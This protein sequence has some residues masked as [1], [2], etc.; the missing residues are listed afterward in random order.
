MASREHTVMFLDK[1]WRE[2]TREGSLR[3]ANDDRAKRG[4]GPKDSRK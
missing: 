3:M 1:L 4:R 2:K